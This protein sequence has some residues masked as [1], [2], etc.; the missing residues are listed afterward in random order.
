MKLSA[1]RVRALRDPGR[2]SDGDGLHLFI[3]KALVCKWAAGSGRRG[4]T[5]GG[6][7]A[8]SYP[9]VA[10]AR[11]G[12]AGQSLKNVIWNPSP[13]RICKPPGIRQANR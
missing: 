5:P 8:G 11:A 9:A 13:R 12:R 7:Y 1:T 2:Y 3:S 10:A 4:R 6:V